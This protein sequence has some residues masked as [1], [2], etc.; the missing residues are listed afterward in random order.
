MLSKLF[1]FRSL[2]PFS[3]YFSP[4]LDVDE[5][6]SDSGRDSILMNVD[7]L[8]GVTGLTTAGRHFGLRRRA[9]RG[10]VNE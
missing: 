5:M 6:W 8:R 2:S 10:G 1:F 9:G 4:I 3:K 7:G